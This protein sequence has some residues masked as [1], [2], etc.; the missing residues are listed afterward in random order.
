MG[1]QAGKPGGRKRAAERPDLRS[2]LRS[3]AQARPQGWNHQGWTE[4]LDDLAAKGHDVSDPDAV[5]WTLERERLAA[6][7]E[8]IRGVG[9]RRV[10]QL[11]DRYET[12]WSLRR[13]SA[14]DIAA[15]AGISRSLAKQIA[16]A[17]R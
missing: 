1:S 6:T 16:Q 4:L 7:L 3:F 10:E 17:L 13:A 5:G 14:E 11:V 2:E 15:T 8:G 12:L 9:P